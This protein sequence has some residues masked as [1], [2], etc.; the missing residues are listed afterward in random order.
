MSG[1]TSSRSC[2]ILSKSAFRSRATRNARRCRRAR[3]SR[4]KER[5]VDALVGAN[6]SPSTKETFRKKLRTGEM[7]EKEIEIE[8]QASGG[9]MPLFEIPGMP[10]A[11]M[12][13]ISIGDIFGKL[14]GGRTKTRRVSV[15]ES[16]RNPDQ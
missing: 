10:G 6:A 9:G 14:G 3:I 4:R 15:K 1:A 5:V 7:D 2:A 13:A 11:Q 8:V 12:G 16:L